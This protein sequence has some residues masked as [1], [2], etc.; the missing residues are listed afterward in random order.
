MLFHGRF[1]Y[2]IIFIGRHNLST[3]EG[4]EIAID[5]II[6]HE[7]YD[8]IYLYNDIALL[9]LEQVAS[10]PVPIP[11]VKAGNDA[12]GVLATVIGWGTLSHNGL[13]P[14]ELNQVSLPIVSQADCELSYPGSITDNM[15]CAGFS[16]G[17]KD[18]C[19]GDSGGPLMVPDALGTG[20]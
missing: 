17:G 1:Q 6:V 19:Q 15:Q 16:Q 12:P 3:N 5:K 18:A 11:L 9:H 4:E 7:T 8:H 20:W 14:D 2:K 13:S 10:Q